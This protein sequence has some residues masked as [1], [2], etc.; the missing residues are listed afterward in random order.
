MCGIAGHFAW[1]AAAPPGLEASGRRFRTASDTEV[2][3]HLY[4]RDGPGMVDGLRGMFALAI[5]DAA[6]RGLFLAR[7][8]FGRRAAVGDLGLRRVHGCP[9]RRGAAGARDRSQSGIS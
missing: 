9:A 3:L 8:G 6:R 2:L 1:S 5:W 4:D 7:D